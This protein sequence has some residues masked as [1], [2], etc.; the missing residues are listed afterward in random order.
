MD[1]E[2]SASM[3]ELFSSIKMLSARFKT[4]TPARIKRSSINFEMAE[5]QV[6]DDE[7]SNFHWRNFDRT[8]ALPQVSCYLTRTN[9]K[10]IDIIAANKESSPMYNGQINAVGAR[11]CPSIEDKAHRY[12]EKNSHHVFLEPEGLKTDTIYPSGISSSLPEEIQDQFIKTISGLENAEIDCYG[13]AVEYDVVDTTELNYGLEH[14]NMPGLY[15]AGQV[16]GTSGYE[17]AAG[18]GFIAGVNAAFAILGRD[19]YRIDRF[20][21]YIGVMIEDLITSTRDEPYRLFTARSE[22]RLY[23]REDNVYQR[24]AAYR[25][26]LGLRADIDLFHVEQSRKWQFLRD[27]LES[28]RISRNDQVFDLDIFKDYKDFSNKIALSELIKWPKIEICSALKAI[29]NL[30]DLNFDT[31]TIKSVAVAIKYDGYIKR[32]E[33][34]QKKVRKLDHLKID[35]KQLCSSENISFECKQRIMKIQPE[36]FGQ[37]KQMEGIRQATLAAVAGNYA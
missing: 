35:W 26:E 11:Y 13:Y 17:E 22:N 28:Y 3:M 9:Q 14:K 16:N 4:G 8:R 19:L 21:S 20:D 5:E 15:F 36:T 6:S 34:E 2:S 29:T 27:F 23:I 7:T 1:A 24:M 12:P 30:Y 25:Q 33:T 18:Q 37:L 31:Y 10:T 32:A